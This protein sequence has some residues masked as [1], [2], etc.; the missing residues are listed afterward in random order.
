MKKVIVTKNQFIILQ[1]CE[2]PQS[3]DDLVFRTSKNPN[4]IGNIVHTLLKHE[5]LIEKSNTYF[6]NIKHYEIGTPEEVRRYRD[7][8][9]R[10][11][12]SIRPD[13]EIKR[14]EPDQFE[15]ANVK[16]LFHEG[17]TRTE[18]ARILNMKKPHVLWTL[19]KMNIQK[20]DVNNSDALFCTPDQ[21]KIF[22]AIE[23][24]YKHFFQ[25]VNRLAMPAD[26]INAG[27]SQLEEMNAIFYKR[28]NN[29]RIYFQLDVNLIPTEKRNAQ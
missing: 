4:V 12:E 22:K 20:N 11:D 28:I 5:Y 2:K 16:K 1:L 9:L 24:P 25:L 10:P 21:L 29:E 6:T 18:I 7:Y 19:E 23:R 8:M 26:L 14:Y 13:R 27:L 15:L 17:R 3:L